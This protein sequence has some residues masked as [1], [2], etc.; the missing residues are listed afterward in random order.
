MR[1]FNTKKFERE[2]K[3][4]L[5]QVTKKCVAQKGIDIECPICGHTIHSRGNGEPCPYCG[6]AIR[7]DWSRFAL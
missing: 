5:E 7:F 4:N 2:L 3:R 6:T 1:S